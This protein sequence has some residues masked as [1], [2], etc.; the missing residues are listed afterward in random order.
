MRSEVV[1]DKACDSME[2]GNNNNSANTNGTF[3]NNFMD[4]FEDINEF[5]AK[6]RRIGLLDKFKT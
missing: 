6:T 1:A 2:Y 3:E 4:N 5:R